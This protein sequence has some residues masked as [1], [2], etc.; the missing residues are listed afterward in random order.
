MVQD[1]ESWELQL[2]EYYKCGGEKLGD[3]TKVMTAMLMLPPDTPSSLMLSLQD[4]RDLEK[5]KNRL[6]Q[7]IRFLEDFGGLKKAAAHIVEDPRAP[8][9]K[10]ASVQA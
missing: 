8:T 2:T 3:K 9:P 6:R 7:N 5:L 10:G 4:V 1:I